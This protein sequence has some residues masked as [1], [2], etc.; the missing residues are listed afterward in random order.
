MLIRDTHRDTKATIHMY[1]YYC[2]VS[3]KMHHTPFSVYKS[4][5]PKYF[6]IFDLNE[7][8]VDGMSFLLYFDVVKHLASCFCKAVASTILVVGSQ[9]CTADK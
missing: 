9:D 1:L 3:L 4:L 6:P 5:R 7:T 2:V 8:G